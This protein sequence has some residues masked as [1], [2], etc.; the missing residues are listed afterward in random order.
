MRDELRLS[1]R[2]DRLGS[3]GSSAAESAP[4][5]DLLGSRVGNNGAARTRLTMI[6]QLSLSLSRSLFARIRIRIRTRA[7][8]ERRGGERAY[9]SINLL[10]AKL[11]STSRSD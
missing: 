1:R 2:D 4:P 5:G 6:D 3:L 8:S 10:L 7:A 11:A 9:T